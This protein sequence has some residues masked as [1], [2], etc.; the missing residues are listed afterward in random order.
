MVT[1]ADISDIDGIEFY[2]YSEDDTIIEIV[3]QGKPLKVV[4]VLASKFKS[5]L[6]HIGKKYSFNEND[7]DF[8]PLRKYYASAI[9]YVLENDEPENDLKFVKLRDE[10][11]YGLEY[12]YYNE[13]VIPQ[14]VDEV[15]KLFFIDGKH[16][17]LYNFIDGKDDYSFNGMNSGKYGY[18]NYSTMIMKAVDPED[19]KSPMK[20][21]RDDFSKIWEETGMN[22]I[23]YNK[24]ADEYNERLS[25]I[26]SKLTQHHI[27]SNEQSIKRFVGM[28]EFIN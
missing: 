19:K 12:V 18:L 28:S 5:E 23:F 9:K 1:R 15:Y 11:G 10:I 8:I 2:E 14:L 3:R 17:L 7:P 25:I 13:I 20:M 6:T 24:W 22:D 4:E 21:S 16:P 27:D 26:F